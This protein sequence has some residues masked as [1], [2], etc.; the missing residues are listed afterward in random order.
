M[1]TNLRVDVNYNNTK[2]LKFMKNMKENR[3]FGQL[4]YS[5]L[6][7]PFTLRKVEELF[8]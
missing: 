5:T 6:T 2:I 3:R 8:K 7:S 4:Y 1:I